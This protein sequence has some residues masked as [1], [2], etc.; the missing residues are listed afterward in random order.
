MAPPC[1]PKTR[2]SSAMTPPPSAPKARS[3]SATQLFGKSKAVSNPPPT[4]ASGTKL[5]PVLVLSSIRGIAQLTE[6]ELLP[7]RQLTSKALGYPCQLHLIRCLRLDNVPFTPL[8]VVEALGS[9]IG[10][11]EAIDYCDGVRCNRVCDAVV[12]D[13][14]ASFGSFP[15][16]SSKLNPINPFAGSKILPSGTSPNVI[17]AFARDGYC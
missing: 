11:Y 6:D 7:V 3:S 5:A 1:A 13:L 12:R 14:L 8:I 4:F 9:L 10:V 16:I 17:M 15:G 2:L